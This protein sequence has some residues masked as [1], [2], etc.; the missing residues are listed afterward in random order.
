MVEKSCKAT[1]NLLK[2]PDNCGERK[3][4]QRPR[5]LTVQD[6]RVSLIA[7]RIAE[8]DVVTTN[9]GNVGRLF[10][11]CE[12]PKR[13]KLQR[14]RNV[15]TCRLQL[16]KKHVYTNKKWPSVVSSETTVSS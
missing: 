11:N 1:M 4:R 2:D 5:C 16:A 10:T 7:R 9:V 14:S 12:H 3:N 6:K 15:N 13:R 8:K